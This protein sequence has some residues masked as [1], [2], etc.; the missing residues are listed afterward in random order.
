MDGWNTHVAFAFV[1]A[2]VDISTSFLGPAQEGDVLFIEC[3]VKKLGRTFA[4]IH[5]RLVLSPTRP[6]AA[7]LVLQVDIMVKE[8]GKM[9][10][11]GKH[12]RYFV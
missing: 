1:G 5:V 7:A 3:T 6:A 8:S 11:T 4:F 9:V 2:S 12:T 10:A